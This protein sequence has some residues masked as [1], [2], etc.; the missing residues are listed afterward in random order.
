[1]MYIFQAT[2]RTNQ[3]LPKDIDTDEY[4]DAFITP[5]Q[6][7]CSERY[8]S[9]EQKLMI[10]V[11]EMVYR[12]LT[13]LPHQCP[14]YKCYPCDAIAWVDDLDTLWPFSFRRICTMLDIESNWLRRGFHRIMTPS[15]Q[16]IEHNERDR[17]RSLE[18]Y[19]AHTKAGRRHKVS[20]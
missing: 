5:E 3:P 11:L 12:D 10:G 2:A 4:G 20:I 18:F 15:D 17:L 16:R 9:G 13:R 6:W 14:R 19:H 7:E 1:M 8:R